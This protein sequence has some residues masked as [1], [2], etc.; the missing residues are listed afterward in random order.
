MEYSYIS[1]LGCSLHGD[2]FW[3]CD[4]SSVINCSAST[5]NPHQQ[6]GWGYTRNWVGMQSEHM[7][8]TD[9]R[10]IPHHMA[11]CSAYKAGET[12]KKQEY[13]QHYSVCL[14]K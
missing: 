2:M 5:T 3:I 13:V 12:K 1:S 9:K 10:D 4:E 6:A 11:S 8:T 14:P 7:A